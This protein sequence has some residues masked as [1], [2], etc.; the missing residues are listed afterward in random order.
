MFHDF[1]H[2]QWWFSTA[3]F[4]Y[5]RVMMWQNNALMRMMW[6]THVVNWHP[7]FWTEAEAH[8]TLQGSLMWQGAVWKVLRVWDHFSI[9]VLLEGTTP[10]RS[11][12][13]HD[14]IT[15]TMYFAD[16]SIT[17]ISEITFYH[18]VMVEQWNW[19]RHS[20]KKMV[21]ISTMPGKWPDWAAEDSFHV[22]CVEHMCYH[23]FMCCISK[24][25]RMS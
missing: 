20:K 17:S 12:A 2:K 1:S 21:D 22:S 18:P 6:E 25:M 15:Q 19:T 5:Q 3:M 14:H 9:N 7:A 23:V 24:I 8:E 4:N 16:T 13:L 11:Q 10:I